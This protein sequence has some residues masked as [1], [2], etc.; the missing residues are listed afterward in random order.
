MDIFPTNGLLR[1]YNEKEGVYRYMPK[2]ID[3]N[4]MMKWSENIVELLQERAQQSAPVKL[5]YDLSNQG[6]ALP[7]LIYT[8]YQVQRLAPMPSF[9]PQ[10]NKLLE[11]HPNL[12][13]MH[14]LVVSP[15]LS[16]KIVSGRK[17]DV[18]EGKMVKS[19]QFFELSAAQDWLARAESA[20]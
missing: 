4:V 16:G 3:A 2:H 1:S 17:T 8:S 15:S 14:A 18:L 13:I 9:Q 20:S 11:Q 19:Q 7:Y 10:I 12:R 5:I 6:V